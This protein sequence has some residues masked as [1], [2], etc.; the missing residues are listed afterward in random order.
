[1]ASS[2]TGLQNGW[3]SGGLWDMTRRVQ[4]VTFIGAGGKTTCLHSITQELESFG[5][6]V[7]ATTTT[8]VFP[9]EHMTAWIS[10]DVPKSQ[11]KACF[12]YAK[13]E[14]KSGKWI[15]PTVNAVDTAISDDLL[16]FKCQDNQESEQTKKSRYASSGTVPNLHTLHWVI[17]G[18]GARGLQLKCWESHEPQI[19]LQSNCAVLVLDR[20]LW[21]NVLQPNQVHRPQRCSD[22]LGRVWNA[23]SSWHYFLGSPVFSTLYR[24][25]AWVI[26]LNG[27]GEIIKTVNP[28]INQS[29]KDINILKELSQKW[30]EIQA[31]ANNLNRPTHLR[32]AVGDAKEGVIQWCDL[33]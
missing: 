6:Q 13:V 24:D 12:W 33:W 1:M 32:L 11:D 31:G 25:F 3:G 21:G 19:P 9:E 20:G 15:G 4:V 28:M 26:L 30:A 5:K 14:D 29:S 2:D 23:E 8:K 27:P 18:D 17:E 16:S 10:D 22:L 7:I